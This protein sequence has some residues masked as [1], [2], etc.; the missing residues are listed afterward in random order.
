MINDLQCASAET[1][2]WKYVDAVSISGTLERHADSTLQH[3]LNTIHNWAT[4]NWMDLNIKKCKEMRICF[5]RQRPPLPSLSID[6][7]HLDIVTSHK[8]VGLTLQNDLKWGSHIDDIVRKASKRLYIIRVLGREGV[9]P[10]ELK[11]IY[12]YLLLGPY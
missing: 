3:D 12:I 7:H 5:F 4:I 10:Q 8:V 6:N 11:L 9:P 1:S 2:T